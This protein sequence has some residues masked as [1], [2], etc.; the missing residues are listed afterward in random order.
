MTA[1]KPTESAVVFTARGKFRV[2]LPTSALKS[3]RSVS[4]GCLAAAALGAYLVKHPEFIR[5][6]VKELLV[7]AGS[8]EGS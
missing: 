2:L 1:L 7:S 8:A 4:S 3:D 5:T 6:A